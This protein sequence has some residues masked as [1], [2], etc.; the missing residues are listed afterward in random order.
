MQRQP[1][2]VRGEKLYTENAQSVQP[3]WLVHLS[4]KAEVNASSARYSLRSSCSL[5]Y[6]FSEK[7]AQK[8]ARGATAIV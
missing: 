1:D 5:S 7:L 3:L 4:S 6:G 2:R 8:A